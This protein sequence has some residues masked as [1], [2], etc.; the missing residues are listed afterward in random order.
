MYLFAKIFIVCLLHQTNIMSVLD[1]AG[2]PVQT[3]NYV[4][5]RNYRQ[6]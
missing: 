5:G 3:V 1:H 6:N 4:C 2:S